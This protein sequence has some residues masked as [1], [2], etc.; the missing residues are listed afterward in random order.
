MNITKIGLF[1][2]ILFPPLLSLANRQEIYK[3]TPLTQQFDSV[4]LH[5]EESVFYDY[6]RTKYDKEINTL[7]NIAKTST[8]TQLKSRA[9]YWQ[10]WII[11]RI[12]PD[13]ALLSISNSLKH[14]NTSKYKYD[15][16]RIQYI[17]GDILRIKGKWTEA[18]II[19]K[20]IAKSFAQNNDNFWQAKTF[21]SIGVILQ[22]LNQ[23]DEALQYFEKADSL[24][25][26]VGSNNCY[27]KNKINISNNLYMLG[28]KADALNILKQIEKED[29]VRKD[30][31]Y[32]VNVLLSIFSV[33]DQKEREASHKAYHLIKNMQYTNLYSLAEMTLGIEMRNLNQNDSAIYYY[34]MAWQSAR[35][36]NDVY[37]MPKILKGLSETFY[38]IGNSDSAYYYMNLANVYQD[39]LLSHN[40]IMEMSRLENRTMLE[41]Y[42]AEIRL[43]EERAN[44]Q[45]NIIFMV[46]MALILIIGMVCYILWLSRRKARMGE[47]LKDVQ[48]RELTLQNKHHLMEI[49]SKNREL[50]SNTLI[51]AQKNAKLKELYDKIEKIETKNNVGDEIKSNIIQH[52]STD[53]DWSYFVIKFEKIYPVFFSN[54]KKLYPNLSETELRLCA[55]IRVGMSAKEIA[56]ILSI[57]PETVNTSR[58]RMRKKMKLTSGE[59]LED[60]LRQIAH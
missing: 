40:K 11:S 29:V 39:S 28:E 6:D 54:L 35:H 15:Y 14:C 30:T 27:I 25:K 13:S 57:Q 12:F 37:N 8:N 58:Y 19:F 22:N 10:A 45:R 3:W 5:L 34:R 50:S 20:N 33:S 18:Y 41:Q 60:I 17:K 21:V 46:S 16:A 31:L 42:E 51:I 32:M 47:Q 49:E 26:N 48:N 2:F 1:I 7:L 38:Q 9:F 4:A 24:F 56:K 55:Y 36:S 44:Y 59:S 43:V 52:L 23:N 53:E